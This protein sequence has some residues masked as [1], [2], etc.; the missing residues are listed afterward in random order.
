MSAHLPNAKP[1]NLALQG[2]GAHGAF[3]WGVLDRLLEDGRLE[4]DGLSATSAGAMNAAVYA[5]GKMTGGAEGARQALET[6]WRK[7]SDAGRYTSPV[8]RLAIDDVLAAFGVNEPVAYRMFEAVTRLMSPYQF[9][10]FNA[11]PL[12]DVLTSVVDFEALTR[13][14]CTNLHISATNVRS[15]DVRVFKNTELSADVVLASA[16]LPMLFQ[17]VEINGEA[18]WDGGYMGN[19]AIYPLIYETQTRDILILHINPIRRSEIPKTP[20]DIY[21]R[22]NEISFNSSLLRELRAIAF[23]TK[24]IE[25]G[26]LKEEH[27]HELKQMRIHA[28]RAD[29]AMEAFSV[30]S[31]FD[32]SWPFLTQLRD[33]GRAAATVW[34]DAKFEDV[35]R[36]S[37]V[38]IRAEYLH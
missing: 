22:I 28:I 21:N 26:W 17:A 12:K 29:E 27:Q 7:I 38:D 36:V 25:E 34:L 8:R 30:V 32:T 20:G 11:N 13:C 37:T 24:L 10:P 33:L 2:G 1:I 14:T 35:G 3:A 23:V 5:Y 18:Y 6:F 16:C 15:G 31:K 9:N 4:I 19:P